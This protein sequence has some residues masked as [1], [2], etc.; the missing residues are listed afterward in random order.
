MPIGNEFVRP[1]GLAFR[2]TGGMDEDSHFGNSIAPLAGGGFVASWLAR[3]LFDG[4]MSWVIYAQR[5]DASGAADG[6]KLLVHQG[7][8]TSNKVVSLSDGGFLVVWDGQAKRY[9]AS[10]VQVGGAFTLV[11]NPSYI[12]GAIDFAMLDD[13]GF[14]ATWNA[15]DGHGFGIAGQRY[16]LNAAPVGAEFQANSFIIGNQGDAAVAALEDGGFIVTWASVDQD[17]SGAGIYAQRYDAASAP[18]GAEFRVNTH[19]PNDQ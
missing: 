13:G 1:L 9:D 19:T 6:S 3:E 17:G 15:D 8:T 11:A 4:L 10:D 18:V 14:L 16:D 7:Q 2:F 12:G 5:Y